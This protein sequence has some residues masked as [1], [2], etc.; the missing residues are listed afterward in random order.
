MVSTLK[1][2]SAWIPIAMSL[3]AVALPLLYV[4]IFGIANEPARDEGVGAHLWQLLT[5]GQFPIIAFFAVKWLPQ[6]PMQ[7]LQVMGFQLLA[8]L[9]ACAPVYYFHL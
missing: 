5:A 7:A 1:H 3:C 8:G 9:A 2:P 4:A 6:K